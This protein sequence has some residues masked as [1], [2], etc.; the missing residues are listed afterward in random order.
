MLFSVSFTKRQQN[1]WR[2]GKIAS[3]ILLYKRKVLVLLRMCTCIL[4]LNPS[5]RMKKGTH[6][7]TAQPNGDQEYLQCF[8]YLF[9]YLF[10]GRQPSDT[11]M[12]PWP[13]P[14]I[15]AA[16]GILE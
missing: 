8:I 1:A 15:D 5:G 9:R 6:D 4:T 11:W 2:E 13:S 14:I 7:V 10:L 12:S 3:T 16:G